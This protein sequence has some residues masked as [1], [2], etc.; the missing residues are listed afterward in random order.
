[1]IDPQK[2]LL[3]ATVDNSATEYALSVCSAN[4]K[5]IATYC[6][7]VEP[8][9]VVVLSHAGPFLIHLKFESVSGAT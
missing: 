6:N 9:V 7:Y 2:G 3:P 8:V 1:M 5:S 4:R